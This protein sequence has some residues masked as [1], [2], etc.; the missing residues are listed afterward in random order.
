MEKSL[1]M[2]DLEIP[3]RTFANFFQFISISILSIS[4]YI[5]LDRSGDCDR[6]ASTPH[7]RRAPILSSG[8]LK[9]DVNYS[10]ECSTPVDRYI[11]QYWKVLET[12]H[13]Q[14][15]LVM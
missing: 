13:T 8:G 6:H 1:G 11:L 10:R 5:E 12:N 2:A 14:F 4:I 9:P 7:R 15:L 3:P